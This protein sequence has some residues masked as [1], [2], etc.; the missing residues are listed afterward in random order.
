M[1]VNY[2]KLF[3]VAYS[4]SI[5]ESVKEAVFDKVELPI[6]EG[7][8]LSS[9]ICE[10]VRFLDN[11]AYSNMSEDLAN[12]IIDDVFEG[13]SEEYLEEVYEVYIQAKSIQYIAEDSDRYKSFS[14]V[15]QGKMPKTPDRYK[16]Y[17]QTKDAEQ[18]M[19]SYGNS[20]K[21]RV[22]KTTQSTDSESWN[23]GTYKKDIKTPKAIQDIIDKAEAR[24]KGNFISKAKEGIKS[25]VGKVKNWWNGRKQKVATAPQ[26]SATA[27]Q[28]NT[29]TSLS[30]KQSI[31][32]KSSLGDRYNEF[33]KNKAAQAGVSDEQASKAT[34]KA[35]GRHK[36]KEAFQGLRQK[37]NEIGQQLDKA[38]STTNDNKK[39]GNNP[40]PTNTGKS[41][42]VNAATG[43]NKVNTSLPSA[44]DGSKEAIGAA[45]GE[46]NKKSNKSKKSSSRG[47]K[48]NNAKQSNEPAKN[49]VQQPSLVSSGD[50]E[51]KKN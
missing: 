49:E 37:S 32:Q 5:P 41:E 21:H 48:K 40:A 47:R 26:Q 2:T 30:A 20:M 10:C 15:M 33:K 8:E 11:L 44:N 16:E 34:Y 43:D 13:C 38:F 9:D 36:R 7:L 3:D 28:Q 1:A 39:E 22:P 29:N 23:A 42:V 51:K 18:L 46:N 25:A 27:P 19:R 14:Q 17:Q 12:S 31:L 45:T 35:I 24:K 6:T 50:D 4:T